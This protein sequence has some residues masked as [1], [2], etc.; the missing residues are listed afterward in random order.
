MKSR[1][2]RPVCI[3]LV[4]ISEGFARS[5][6]RYLG[7]DQ[8]FALTGAAPDVA[9]A[10]ALL[11]IARPDVVLLDWATLNGASREKVHALRAGRPELRIACA[12]SERGAYAAAAARAG[13]DAIIATDRFGA[14]LESALRS[15]F[16][17]RFQGPNEGAQP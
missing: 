15:L 6:A 8:R 12:V 3:F 13:A 7:A 14:D 10:G 11:S 9:R 5:L 2:Q 4:G 16:P 17:D 1:S